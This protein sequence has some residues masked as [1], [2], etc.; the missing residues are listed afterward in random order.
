[1]CLRQRAPELLIADYCLPDGNGLELVQDSLSLPTPP[2]AML[3]TGAVSQDMLDAARRYGA[4]AV[5]PKAAAP[6]QML[7]LARSALLN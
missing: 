6:D 1:M 2:A 4:S 3:I 7:E 5:I